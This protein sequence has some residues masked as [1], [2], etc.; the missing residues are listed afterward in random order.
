MW[1]IS[2]YYHAPPPQGGETPLHIS[3]RYC[4]RDVAAELLLFV[5][6]ERSRFDAVLLVNTQNNVS[7]LCHTDN[8]T[9]KPR[10]ILRISW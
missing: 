9:S 5:S 4:H 3:V 2:I 1:T 8:C 6:K 7:Q 10:I